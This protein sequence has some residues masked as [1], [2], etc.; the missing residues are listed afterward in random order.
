ML[1]KNSIILWGGI[2]LALLGPPERQH[3]IGTGAY[4]IFSFVTKVTAPKS[5]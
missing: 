3:H 2:L 4:G 1:G 5:V